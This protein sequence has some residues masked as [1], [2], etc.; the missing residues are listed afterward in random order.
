MV[1]QNL[2]RIVGAQEIQRRLYSVM[3]A[4]NIKVVSGCHPRVI[5]TNTFKLEMVSP[6]AICRIYTI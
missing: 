5:F 2:G 6:D 1:P 4:M 3:L